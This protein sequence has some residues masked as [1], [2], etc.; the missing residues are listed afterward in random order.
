MIYNTWGQQKYWAS[1]KLKAVSVKNKALQWRVVLEM[2]DWWL[3]FIKEG[4]IKH[5]KKPAG[6][7]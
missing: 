4:L 2:Q 7:V 5:R 3:A 1:E 6:L